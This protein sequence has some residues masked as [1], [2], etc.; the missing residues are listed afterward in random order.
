MCWRK[1]WVFFMMTQECEKYVKN[2]PSFQMRAILKFDIR[3][4]KTG[5]FYRRKWSKLHKKD[6]ILH[7]DNY[8]HL[9]WAKKDKS[10]LGTLYLFL[11]I[12]KKYLMKPKPVKCLTM[13]PWWHY[14]EDAIR[15]LRRRR[16]RNWINSSEAHCSR[17]YENV[18][19]SQFAGFSRIKLYF[20]VIYQ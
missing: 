1:F 12:G 13:T 6:T 19:V 18:N 15:H 3:K 14:C 17:L 10:N 16:E 5:T 11:W 9:Q 8:I 4:K 7:N 2:N 20:K